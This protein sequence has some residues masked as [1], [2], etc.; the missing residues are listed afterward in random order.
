MNVSTTNTSVTRRTFLRKSVQ[1]GAGLS[2]AFMLPGCGKWDP[3]TADAVTET[4]PSFEPNAFIKISTDNKIT[5]VI[6]KLEMGQG[7]YT[8]LATVVAEELDADWDQIVVESALVDAKRYGPQGTGGSSS[9]RTTYTPMREAGA[10]ARHMLIAAAATYWQV[11]VEEI[12][13][14]RGTLRHTASKRQATFGELATLAAQQPIPASITLKDPKTFTLI[15]KTLPRK[16]RGKTDGTAVFTQD[17]QLPGM[18][19]AVVAHSPRFGAKLVN[20]DSIAAKAVSGVVDVV[21]LEN[22]VAVLA[23]TFWQAKKA[24]DLLKIDW[25]EESAFQQSTEE[26]FVQYHQLA[27]LS[28][29]SARRE[30]DPE[31]AFKMA[32]QTIEAS[33]EFP[34]LTHA[35]MEPMNCVVQIKDKQ[36]EFWYG[37]QSQTQD[38][39]AIA[40][41]L[42]FEPEQVKINTLLAGGS[43]GRRLT[44]DYVLEATRIAKAFSKP[45]PIKLV[46]TREDDTQGGYFRPMMVHK[47]KAGLDKQGNII[48][49]QQRIVGQ[50]IM[51]SLYG[52]LGSNTVDRSTV[53]G[54]VSLPYQIPNLAIE[55]HIV[56]LP[57]PILYWRSVDHSH[58]AFAKEAFIDELAINTQQDPVAFRMK[59]LAN[60]PKHR[61]VLQLAAEKAHWGEPLPLGKARG[62]A[63]H[64]SFNTIVAQVAE[65]SVAEDGNYRVEK[66]T[67]VV[68]CGL[69]V[70][71]DVV[72]A[73]MEGGIGFGLSPA[74]LS[75]ITFKDGRVVQSSFHDYQVVRMK[76]MPD[77]QVHIVPSSEPPTGVGEPGVPVI[78]PAVANALYAATGSSKRSLPFGLII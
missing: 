45:V 23:Q 35:A 56:D 25:N 12:E 11:A 29:A 26:L 49:W 24:R 58:T 34:F 72:T 55:Q 61:K 38:Q 73:Q 66:V 33:Y 28:G 53:E 30:G 1:S 37:C 36:A 15:G 4:G 71:P 41:L 60:H 2:L 51:T 42:G 67:C 39:K 20:V 64:E 57:V 76:D 31:A 7:T 8:G 54:A 74:L 21:L 46:W 70:N 59:L 43:F 47:L 9:I 22:A 40:K 10:A 19:T 50:S 48:A 62:V 44:Y 17:I 65:V 68:D 18:L 69:A 14:K 6:T 78:A 77:I 32:H 52:G 75:E 16:D 27:E 3:G 13:V 63:L 5:V